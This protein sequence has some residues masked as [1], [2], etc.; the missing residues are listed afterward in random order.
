MIVGIVDG[1]STHDMT[2]RLLG[3]DWI[4]FC[5]LF[6]SVRVNGNILHVWMGW[7]DLHLDYDG[8]ISAK[9]NSHCYCS[10]TMVRC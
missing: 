3:W 10:F 2:K 4:L 1:C 6:T 8:V 9:E 5:F 7:L